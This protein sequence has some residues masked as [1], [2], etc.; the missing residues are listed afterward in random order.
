[1]PIKSYKIDEGTLQIGAAL[2]SIDVTAQV[3]EGLVSWSEDVE[4]TRPTLSGEE[5][6]GEA[7]YTATL[8]LKLI[9]DLDE[10]GLVEFTWEH[11]GE[12]LP[13]EFSP[14][15]ATGR[16]ITGNLRIAPMNVGGPVRTRPS[17]DVSWACIG[18]PVLGA[19][20]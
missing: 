4:D 17:S 6:A 8:E 10:A 1:M 16:T 19:S 2:T 9:Q 18:K 12:I 20:L 5:L 3:E 14:A 13:F 7:T 15:T 11:M